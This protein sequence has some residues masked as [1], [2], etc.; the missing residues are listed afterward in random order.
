MSAQPPTLVGRGRGRGRGIPPPR[1]RASTETNRAITAGVPLP[2]PITRGGSNI[3]PHQPPGGA[4]PVL[5]KPPQ[6][7]N[8]PNEVLPRGGSF[9][10]P[11][12]LKKP[13]PPPVRAQSSTSPRKS[14]INALQ[15]SKGASIPPALV[16]PHEFPL[17]QVPK[18]PPAVVPRSRPPNKELPNLPSQSSVPQKLKRDQFYQSVIKLTQLPL[19]PADRG[20][21]H[22]LQLEGMDSVEFSK[23]EQVFSDAIKDEPEELKPLFDL[24]KYDFEVCSRSRN[25]EKEHQQFLVSI[26]FFLTFN[27]SLEYYELV[28]ILLSLILED[29]R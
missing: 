1:K 26:S 16:S 22:V 12:V 3:K 17:P 8:P 23:Y 21:I 9:Q 20:S 28:I 7:I 24:S 27:D 2:A 18:I 5:H 13:P 15:M 10:D 19:T 11:P 29:I 6:S 25:V 4:L 14:P